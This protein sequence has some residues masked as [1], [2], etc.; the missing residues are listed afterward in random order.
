ML[1]RAMRE[2]QRT[3][4]PSP[5]ARQDSKPRVTDT[6]EWRRGGRQGGGGGGGGGR[7]VGRREKSA[8]GWETQSNGFSPRE[9]AG[10]KDRHSK[11]AAKEGSP[12]DDLRG[13]QNAFASLG[14]EEDGDEGSGGGVGDGGGE[15]AQEAAVALD[16]E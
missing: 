14:L 3:G 4:R 12:L 1:Y 8:D 9:G 5:Y 15:T 10:R 13:P 11:A 16:A 6:R 2:R 7:A